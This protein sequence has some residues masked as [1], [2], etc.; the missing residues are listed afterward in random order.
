MP[1]YQVEWVTTVGVLK[2]TF[3]TTE[4]GSNYTYTLVAVPIAGA[5][6][7]NLA[8]AS[9]SSTGCGFATTDP[10]STYAQTLCFVNFA[11]W[12]TQTGASSLPNYCASGY[13]A[14]SAGVTGTPFTLDFCMQVVATTTATGRS[15]AKRVQE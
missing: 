2:V 15:R 3:A 1:A 7:T 9:S 12:N 6:T 5:S 4:P 11:P 13:L 10:Q 14:M 8:S